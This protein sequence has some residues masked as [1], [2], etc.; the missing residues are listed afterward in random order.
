MEGKIASA[1][2]AVLTRLDQVVGTEYSVVLYGSRARGEE[3]AASDYNLLVVAD[4]LEP[5]RLR[6]LAATL[7]DLRAA[8]G[9]PP[10]LIEL[11]EWRR[12]ADVFP[13]ELTDMG[14][15]RQVLRGEDPVAGVH[16][17]PADL[18]RA[19]EAELRAKLIRLRQ[20]FAVSADNP[21]TLGALG[22]GASSTLL[23]MFRA[24]LVLVSRPAGGA[25]AVVLAEAAAML[26]VP[27]DAI[28]RL[29]AHRGDRQPR[30]A[31]EEFI[32]ILTAVSA[33]VGVIDRFLP[34][35]N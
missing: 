35:G 4:H 20:A 3:H 9:A 29:H 7:A 32:Q 31:A 21:K 5:E 8:G 27:T 23:A 28:A 18:R 12:A 33:A 13:I 1:L 19:L 26:G 34:G 6:A 10:L 16:V 17:E 25:P 30:A 15:A 2:D 24:T 14:L 22:A 11:E